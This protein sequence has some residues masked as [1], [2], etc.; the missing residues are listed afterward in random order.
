MEG[1]LQACDKLGAHQVSGHLIM[2]YHD[3]RDL[4]LDFER[5]I[6]PVNSTFL[7][8][9][10]IDHTLGNYSSDFLRDTMG[11]RI[12][13]LERLKC[14]DISD[15]S[16]DD[17][18]DLEILRGQLESA[19][20]TYEEIM[21]YQRMADV[22]P[23]IAMYGIYLLMM[24]E[25]GNLETRC[26]NILTRLSEVP[27]LM[28]QGKVN[29]SSGKNIP[30]AWTVKAIE[31][32]SG[33]V[34]F[35]ASS[36]R[37]FCRSIPS[38][39]ED[40]EKASK[41][42][43][44]A[45]SDYITFLKLKILPR[46]TGKFAVGTDLFN[47]ILKYSHLLPYDQKDLL[48]IGD[49][50]VSKTIE[51][52]ERLSF[53]I[54]GDKNWMDIISKIKNDCYRKDELLDSY[55]K[56]MKRAKEFVLKSELM[57]VPEDESL[58]MVYT[59]SFERNSIPFAAYVPPAPFE[60]KQQGIFWITPVNENLSE[61][62]QKEQ[63][64]NHNI[65]GVPL[66]VLHE[67][68]PGHH[69]QIVHSNRVKSP[70]RKQFMSTVFAEGWAL[71]CEELMYDHGYYSDGRTRMVKLKD[72]LC[73]ACRVVIDVS[74]HCKGMSIDKATQMLTDIARLEKLPAIAEVVRYTSSPTQPMS[75]II[76]KMQIKNLLNEVRRKEKLDFDLKYFHDRLLSYGTIPLS[77]IRKAMFAQSG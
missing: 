39:S 65:W 68:Y 2:N 23:G 38:L 16:L 34:E 70:V 71:Y 47:H 37:D 8:I 11:K 44:E 28:E 1:L 36:F 31:S 45:F 33:G 14:V 12:G 56:E 29:L 10:D 46:S 41:K 75:Y 35:F 53:R 55:T 25:H 72:Q 51:E 18:I 67:A 42:A 63:L 30:E 73:G 19:V 32:A 59:P 57:T 9:H 77:L 20:R 15:L 3:L 62:L 4:I 48:E 27:S 58:K 26:G 13:N 17:D 74:L 40:M 61:D 64:K 66:T 6:N 50:A 52:M 22:Y 49:E 24:R 54:S 5:R 69:L 76:G 21:P 43:T 60:D 7:G